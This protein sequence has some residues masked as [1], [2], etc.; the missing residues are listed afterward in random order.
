MPLNAVIRVMLV[1]ALVAGSIGHAP[2]MAFARPG[3]AGHQHPGAKAQGMPAA[4]HAGAHDAAG[5]AHHGE[6]EMPASESDAL[7]RCFSLNCCVALG[8]PVA[9][10]PA[11]AVSFA[12]L[13]V[14][15]ASA[16]CGRALDPLERPPRL[17]V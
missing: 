11:P 14:L 10:A 15:A 1:L 12:V 2:G 3:G 6:H 7:I 13:P 4:H 9:V 8:A 5:H 17:Q 16:L